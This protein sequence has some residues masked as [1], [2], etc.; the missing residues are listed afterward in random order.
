[1]KP[2]PFCDSKLLEICD[3]LFDLDDSIVVRCTECDAE[4]PHAQSNEDAVKKWD[5][6]VEGGAA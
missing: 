2:C 5:D 3:A 4:G 1:M 6:R